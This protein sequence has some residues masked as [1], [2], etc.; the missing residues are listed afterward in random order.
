M[1]GAWGHRL[2]AGANIDNGGGSRG[3]TFYRHETKAEPTLHDPTI[4]N[5]RSAILSNRPNTFSFRVLTVFILMREVIDYLLKMVGKLAVVVRRRHQK[6]EE[7][8]MVITAHCFE[9]LNQ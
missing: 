3:E 9:S 2:L 7:R 5:M 1:K 6:R 4:T 8:V